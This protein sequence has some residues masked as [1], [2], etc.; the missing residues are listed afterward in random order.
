MPGT[1]ETTRRSGA[2]TKLISIM[3]FR[4]PAIYLLNKHFENA[5]G[6]WN[7]SLSPF[8]SGYLDA[9]SRSGIPPGLEGS[10]PYP[11]VGI[12]T[13]DLMDRLQIRRLI[14]TAE[15]VRE[16][17]DLS[18]TVAIIDNNE[19]PRELQNV[20]TRLELGFITRRH[21]DN[22]YHKYKKGIPRTFA[23]ARQWITEKIFEQQAVLK[24]RDARIE[25]ASLTESYMPDLKREYQDGRIVL[26]LVR[27]SQ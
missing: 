7:L 13:I 19:I 10:R 17:F 14:S 2:L 1:N 3:P 8:G 20:M 27:G 11:N 24:H 18:Q 12:I 4:Y 21:L 5:E 26:V 6:E 16:R 15:F 23:K 22:L 25:R 9:V